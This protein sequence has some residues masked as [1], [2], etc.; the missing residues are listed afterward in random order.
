MGIF[1]KIKKGAILI[2]FFSVIISGFFWREYFTN[3][4]ENARS[5]YTDAYWEFEAANDEWRRARILVGR[6]LEDAENAKVEVV[7]VDIPGGSGHYA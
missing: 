5:K 6:R 7:F 4:Y 3:R 1:Q 2:C